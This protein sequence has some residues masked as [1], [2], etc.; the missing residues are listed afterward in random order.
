MT[1]YDILGVDPSAD[2]AAVRKAYL[3]L[4][5]K[6]HPDKNPNSQEEAK[7]KFIEIGTGACGLIHS[8]CDILD[9]AST[10]ISKCS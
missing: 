3:K 8:I 1:Y 10:N 4:S 7:A 2:Q 6:H 5:L 9:F